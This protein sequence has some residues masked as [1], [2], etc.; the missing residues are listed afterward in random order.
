MTDKN[1]IR[2][3]IEIDGSAKLPQGK[4]NLFYEWINGFRYPYVA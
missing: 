1:E 3:T 4:A 2:K